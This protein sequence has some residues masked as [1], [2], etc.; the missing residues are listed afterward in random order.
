[1]I[2]IRL[3]NFQ[4]IAQAD[5]TVDGLTV[6]AGK[7]N[8]GK[9]SVVRAY[10]GLFNNSPAKPYV[11]TGEKSLEVSLEYEDGQ[12]LTWRKGAGVNE[13]IVNG[14]TI[15]GGQTCPDE[16]REVGGTY[17]IQAGTST[18][19]PQI[20]SQEEGMNFLTHL[21]GSVLADAISDA[22]RVG[23]LN[24][25][26][27]SAEKDL[28]TASSTLKVRR[29]D[30]E[31]VQS[32]VA[33]FSGLSMTQDL[34]AQIESDC[35]D[36]H[37]LEEELHWVSDWRD[38]YGQVSALFESLS[39]VVFD[40]PPESLF[41]EAH[42]LWDLYVLAEADLKRA[43][44]IQAEIE[45]L[46]AL[47]PDLLD[48]ESCIDLQSYDTALGKVEAVYDR[49]VPLVRMLP[50]FLRLEEMLSDWPVTFS[51]LPDTDQAEQDWSALIE[52]LRFR[53]QILSANLQLEN[54]VSEL[55]DTV[56]AYDNAKDEVSSL[57]GELEECPICGTPH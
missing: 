16:V 8:S 39:E 33:F 6:L 37:N 7:S 43:L 25:A 30:L 5:I 12:T 57:L 47:L 17:P 31:A 11:R 42:R 40:L 53:D 56:V 15:A 27:K 19:W 54:I 29:Q 51:D 26:L 41:E 13:Y 22:E 48:A 2:R 14:K 9:T 4:S 18:I 35:V 38:Q 32:D 23:I 36:T 24:R 21:P 46:E 28:R 10:R 55:N 1:M 45:S 52:C 44:E 50:E 3:K 20:A 34:V 49:I